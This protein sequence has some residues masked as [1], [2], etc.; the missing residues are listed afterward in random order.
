LL[1]AVELLVRLLSH[2]LENLQSCGLSI[3]VVPPDT[4]VYAKPSVSERRSNLWRR[5]SSRGWSSAFSG[6]ASLSS[7]LASSSS[8]R[9][10]ASV[11]AS[12]RGSLPNVSPNLPRSP[13]TETTCFHT[14]SC[15]SSHMGSMLFSTLHTSDGMFSSAQV[16]SVMFSSCSLTTDISLPLV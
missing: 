7:A 12:N 5:T 11:R 1:V 2:L 4:P 10:I 15:Y 8:A 9:T 3:S 14:A 6:L 16:C 13:N